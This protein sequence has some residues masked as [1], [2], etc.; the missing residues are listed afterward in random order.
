MKKIVLIGSF[1][2]FVFLTYGAIHLGTY[3]NIPDEGEYYQKTTQED[4]TSKE[5]YE[6]KIANTNNETW[7]HD[8]VI[9]YKSSKTGFLTFKTETDTL[10]HQVVKYKQN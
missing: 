9:V 7:K 1:L 5:L 8:F 4:L 6:R 3:L 2:F 10:S